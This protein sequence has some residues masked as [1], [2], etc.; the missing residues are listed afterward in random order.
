M[1]SGRER[2]RGRTPMPARSDIDRTESG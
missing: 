2:E 1:S